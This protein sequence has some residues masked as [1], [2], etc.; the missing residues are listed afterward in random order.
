MIDAAR[1]CCSPH[2][3]R[4]EVRPSSNGGERSAGMDMAASGG[5]QKKAADYGRRRRAQVRMEPYGIGSLFISM[6]E[7]GPSIRQVLG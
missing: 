1:P 6:L 5:L 3:N 7:N 4:V 2:L